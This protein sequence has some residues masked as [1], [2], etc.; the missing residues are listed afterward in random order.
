[1]MEGNMPKKFN[2]LEEKREYNRN[3]MAAWRTANPEKVEAGKPAAAAR[4]AEWLKNAENRERNRKN[5][6]RIRAEHK[7]ADPIA[8]NKKANERN[9]VIRAKVKAKII[10]AYGGKCSCEGCPVTE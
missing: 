1:M 3:T 9:K 6:Q 7:A 2:S 4:T 8:F 5:M 10:A